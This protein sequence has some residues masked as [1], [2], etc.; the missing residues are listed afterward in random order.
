[1]P[2]LSVPVVMLSAFKVEEAVSFVASALVT[3]VEKL[4]SSPKA[5][6]NSFNVFKLEGELSTKA[7]ISC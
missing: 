3:V 4:A 2:P 6:A 1:M 5:A 7:A